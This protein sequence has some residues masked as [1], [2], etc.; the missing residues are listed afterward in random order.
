MIPDVFRYFLI[1]FGGTRDQRPA[2]PLLGGTRDP[3]LT[4]ALSIHMTH[5]LT[6]GIMNVEF[7]TIFLVFSCNYK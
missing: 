4:T 7:L 5:N 3:K 2:T 6:P 1:I